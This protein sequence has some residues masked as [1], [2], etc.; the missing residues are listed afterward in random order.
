MQSGSAISIWLIGSG[1]VS[2]IPSTKAKT[3]ANLRH[4][5]SVSDE[6]TPNQPN[7]NMTSGI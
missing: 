7:T 4:L 6:I 3:I 5:R 1:G 2:T